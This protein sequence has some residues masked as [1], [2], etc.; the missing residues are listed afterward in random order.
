MVVLSTKPFLSRPDP[1]VR[2]ELLVTCQR[3]HTGPRTLLK[4]VFLFRGS[5]GHDSIR[6]IKPYKKK[7]NPNYT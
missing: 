2:V 6:E 7:P 4:N 1:S 3:A 5:V